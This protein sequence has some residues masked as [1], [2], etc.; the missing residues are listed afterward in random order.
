MDRVGSEYGLPVVD[1][2]P[3]LMERGGVGLFMDNVHPLEAGGAVIAEALFPP[4]HGLL[5]EPK[6]I[7]GAPKK[8][9]HGA[10]E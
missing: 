8:G 2:T 7:K 5:S 3:M 1:P 6:P 9:A 4:V 10:G